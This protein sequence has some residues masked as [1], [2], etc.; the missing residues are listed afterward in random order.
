MAKEIFDF[1][2]YPWHPHKPWFNVASALR[3]CDH[4]LSHKRLLDALL[5]S[6]Y[7]QAG[8]ASRGRARADI[9]FADEHIV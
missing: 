5:A 4:P 9:A 8:K 3:F 1:G 7:R 2:F 6:T